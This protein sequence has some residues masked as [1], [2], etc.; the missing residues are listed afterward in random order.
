MKE[1]YYKYL[2]INRLSYLEDELLRFT[3]PG[4]LNDPFECLPKKPSIEEFD[5]LINSLIPENSNKVIQKEIKAKYD[6]KYLDELY[7]TQVEKVNEDIGIFS[8]SKNWK[9]SLMWAHY[10]ESHKGFCVGFDSKN[11][12]FKKPSYALE[13]GKTKN[14]KSVT[15]FCAPNL[16]MASIKSSPSEINSLISGCKY[17]HKKDFL[18]T[19]SMIISLQI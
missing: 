5:N 16:S 8:L 7:K 13:K 4:D 11:N 9:S 3:Q 17:D 15:L 2:P 12:F 19:I 6:S 18:S 10:T 1:H 14:E